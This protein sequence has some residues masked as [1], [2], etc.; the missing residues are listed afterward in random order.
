MRASA[1]IAGLLLSVSAGCSSV[2]PIENM[3]DDLTDADSLDRA[4]AEIVA[5]EI[6]PGVAVAVVDQG[7]VV[8]AKGFGRA[9]PTGSRE[10]LTTSPFNLWS[11]SKVFTQLAVLSL[12]ESGQIGLEDPVC[13]HTGWLEYS[14]CRADESFADRTVRSLLAHSAGIPDL[15]FE[16]YAQTRFGNDPVVDQRALANQLL[17]PMR[18]WRSVAN[19]SS[20]SNSHYLLLGAIVEQVTGQP[21]SAVLE[22]R[23]LMPLGLGATGYRA[24]PEMLLM[25]GSHP[26]DLTSFMAFRFVDKKRAV[27]AR[28]NGRYWFNPVYNAA[29]GSTGLLSTGADMAKSARGVSDLTQKVGWFVRAETIGQSFS[30][31]GS[32]MAY[33]SMLQLFPEQDRG[34]FVVANDTYFDRRGG[35]ALSSAIAKIQW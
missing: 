4:L 17:P 5:A 1:A 13:L 21:L 12:V 20:Y 23:V 30:H 31:G 11:V 28:K 27:A 16:L 3:V 22:E 33:T 15:G 34:V 14:R 25:H 2:S 29:L 8:Y 18:K 35:L 10:I 9:A 6:A 24:R 26:V 32:G 19:E 7:Q